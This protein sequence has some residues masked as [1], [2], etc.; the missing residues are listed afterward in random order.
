MKNDLTIDIIIF[1]KSRKACKVFEPV[2]FSETT[3]NKLLSFTLLPFFCNL[4]LHN[5][6]CNGVGLACPQQF[7]RLL[8]YILKPA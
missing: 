2:C 3:S 8:K 5:Q 4:K 6:P 7:F 1:Q